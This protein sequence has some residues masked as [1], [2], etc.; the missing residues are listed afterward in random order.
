LL[1]Q[2]ALLI[3]PALCL[4]FAALRST[5]NPPSVP[6][7]SQDSSHP[8]VDLYA[9]NCPPTF[10]RFLSVW[11]D[12]V[13]FIQALS[14]E[15]QHDLA[16][17]ICGLP[18]QQDTVEPT[19]PSVAADLRA[20][21][22]EIS[23]R[24]SFQDRYAAD[25]QAVIDSGQSTAP[26][27]SK[28][29]VTFVPPPV[30]EPTSPVTPSAASPQRPSQLEPASA[31]PEPASNALL[32]PTAPAQPTPTATRTAE[33]SRSPSPSSRKRTPSPTILADDAQAIDFIRETLYA[34][35]LDVLSTRPSLRS[36]LR[37]DPARAYFASVALAILHISRTAMTDRGSVIGVL[38]K[39]LTL[40][41]C[42]PE[43]KGLMAELAVVGKMASEM[44]R[45][46][47]EGALRL[48]EAGEAVPVPRLERVEETLEKG[49]GSVRG[50]R[51]SRRSIEGRAVAFATQV[52][53]LSLRLTG[54]KAF[55][56]RQREVFKILGGIS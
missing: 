51:G 40:A 31:P 37:S 9:D 32:S 46:D 44:E 4:Y 15:H 35:L 11:A 54:L 19:L 22:I 33:G 29:K 10:S 30:Y 55:K 27:S 16:R 50:G 21:A 13:P 47:T 7:P 28:P 36:L 2:L 52:N 26:S 41:D 24:R 17:L 18:A 12:S 39:E 43:L 56:Q 8:P 20:V 1:T 6:L 14:P 25:L 48:A 38:G 42:P 53:A 34:A 5:T 45:E 23:Q 49:I 3:G